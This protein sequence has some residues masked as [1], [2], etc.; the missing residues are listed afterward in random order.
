[1]LLDEA[2]QQS[3]VEADFQIFA[4]DAA[5]ELVARASRGLFREQSLAGVSAERRARYF[6]NVDGAYRVKR[7]LRE[8]MIFAPQDLIADPPLSQLDLVTCRNL[9]IYLK[10]ETVKD[11]LFLMHRSLRKGGCLFLG[12]SEPYQ[13]EDKGFVAVS[14]RWNIYRK[15]GPMPETGRSVL[16]RRSVS[17]A[18]TSAVAAVRIA[19]ERS[20][21]P[22]ALIDDE[23]TVLRIYGDTERILKLPA[24]EPSLKL[25]DL[26]PRQWSSL[27]RLSVRQALRDREPLTLTRLF[28]WATGEASMNVRLM[29]LHTSTGGPCDRVLVSFI[30]YADVSGQSAAYKEELA[31]LSLDGCPSPDWEDEARIR[32]KKWTLRARSCRP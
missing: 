30:R 14:R 3:G 7:S 17:V 28:D 8:K 20:D 10:P 31:R 21:I 4:T 32:E 23:C 9:L 16:G 5:P 12:K 15:V 24:G 26:V 19:A 25:N 22:S 11:V 29:P 2:A 13:L 6:Y 27:L 1:M 18:D